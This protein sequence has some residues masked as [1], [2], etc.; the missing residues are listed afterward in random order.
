MQRG[1]SVQSD[2][3]A[4]LCYNPLPPYEVTET[5]AL[6]AADLVRIKNFARFWELIVNR[7]LFPG[8]RSPPIAPQAIPSPQF[9]HFMS[10][11]DALLARFGRNWG[12][13]KTEL[14]AAVYELTEANHAYNGN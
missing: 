10:L 4:G 6:P 5:A 3:G 14:T 8:P 9:T 11:S 13:D 1:T 12:I 7:P 2:L